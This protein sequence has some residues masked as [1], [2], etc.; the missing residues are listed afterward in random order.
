MLKSLQNGAPLLLYYSGRGSNLIGGHYYIL[1]Y[2][3]TMIT[4]ICVGLVDGFKEY[5][6]R[7]FSS[8]SCALN[9]YTLSKV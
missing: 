3:Q 2:S 7:Q 4:Q 5:L 1:E 8:D 9:V 6:D